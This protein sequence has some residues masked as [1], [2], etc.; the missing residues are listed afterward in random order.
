MPLVLFI[1]FIS[2]YKFCT[3]K[4]IT[5]DYSKFS[6]KT[7]YKQGQHIGTA[8]LGAILSLMVVCQISITYYLHKAQYLQKV[9]WKNL[10]SCATMQTLLKAI[11]C[12]IYVVLL[13]SDRAKV[14]ISGDMA[15]DTDKP[16]AQQLC[17]LC[18]F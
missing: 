4:V 13:G 11:S 17:F 16:L 3:V 18:T 9:H 12:L 5:N 1:Y 7:E 10:A 6:L 2:S 15:T 8:L 14:R